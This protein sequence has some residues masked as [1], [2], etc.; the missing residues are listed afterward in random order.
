MAAI[1]LVSGAPRWLLWTPRPK[2]SAS[3]S[4]IRRWDQVIFWSR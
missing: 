3:V 2:F 4:A 1:Q